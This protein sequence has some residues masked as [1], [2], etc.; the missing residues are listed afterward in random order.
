[1][2]F[3]TFGSFSLPQQGVR[4]QQSTRSGRPSS[5]LRLVDEL[6]GFRLGQAY[7]TVSIYPGDFLVDAG[8]IQNRLIDTLYQCRFND[9][10]ELVDGS[11]T[12]ETIWQTRDA[13]DLYLLKAQALIELNRAGEARELLLFLASRTDEEKVHI[14][15]ARARLSFYDTDYIKAEALF[16]EG[17][18]MAETARDYFRAQLGLLLTRKALD[19]ID[20]IKKSMEELEELLPVV[21]DDLRLSF[22]L[23]RADVIHSLEHRPKQAEKIYYDVISE[24]ARRNWP[25]LMMKSLFMLARNFKAAGKTD[26][27]IA[28][29]RILQCLMDPQECVF[30]NQLVS[31]DFDDE[32]KVLTPCCE[33][34][35]EYKR[36]RFSKDWIPLHDKPLLYKFLERLSTE[37]YFVSKKDIAEYL[38]PSQTYKS[39][40]HD[41]RIFDIARRVR[42]LIEPCAEKP[43]SLLSGRFGYRLALMQ[44]TAEK[45]AARAVNDVPATGKDAAGQEAGRTTINHVGNTLAVGEQV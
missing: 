16:T 15:Y 26:L 2:M 14:L 29:L 8:Q 4:D 12:P 28:N 36:V 5:P 11:F 3:M 43:V 32:N 30:L 38:W 9:A 40:T 25:Y 45:P 7:H 37:E 20:G 44:K 34:D 33:F 31:R 42:M 18:G 19:K 41:A 35:A 1:M 13:F 22:E 24:A 27:S 17:L 23:F 6:F 10:I 21:N 39:R